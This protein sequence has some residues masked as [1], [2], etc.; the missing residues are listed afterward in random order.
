MT[1]FI[2]RKPES[3]LAERARN[4][5]AEWDDTDDRLV[6]KLLSHQTFGSLARCDWTNSDKE[7]RKVERKSCTG[8]ISKCVPPPPPPPAR[9]G[10]DPASS[11]HRAHAARRLW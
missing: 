7:V 10:S 8:R 6:M 4:E 1:C 9:L 3:Q 11:P 2:G 5:Q